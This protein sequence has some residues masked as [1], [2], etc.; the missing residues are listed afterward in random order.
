MLPEAVFGDFV[1]RCLL[2]VPFFL[3]FGGGCCLLAVGGF[4][5]LGVVVRMQH[6]RL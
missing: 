3:I 1:I 5:S 2:L 4:R 6:W